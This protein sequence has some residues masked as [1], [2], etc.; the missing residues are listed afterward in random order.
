MNKAAQAKS[1][2]DVNPIIY[3]KLNMKNF[4]FV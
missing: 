3:T 2:S 4:L 1:M